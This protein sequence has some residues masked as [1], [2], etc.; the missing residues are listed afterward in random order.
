MRGDLKSIAREIFRKTLAAIDLREALA[1]QLQRDGHVLHA[2]GTAIDLREFREI[3]G[4]AFGKAA[5][6][7]ARVLDETLSPEYMVDGLLVVPAAPIEN[8]PRW[9][10]FVGGHPMPNEGSFAAGRTIAVTRAL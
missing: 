2:D 9:A 6:G 1:R 8:L 5:F 4:V 3:V 10:T 7:M